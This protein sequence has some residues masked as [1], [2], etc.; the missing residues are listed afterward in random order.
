MTYKEAVEDQIEQ[1]MD[2]FEFHKAEKIMEALDWKWGKDTPCA[3]ELRKTA[4][5]LLRRAAKSGGWHALG[6][7]IAHANKGFDEE[8]NRSYLWLHLYFGLDTIHEGTLHD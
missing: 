7:L 2:D 4:R 8:E 6:G 3:A 1:I 5:E